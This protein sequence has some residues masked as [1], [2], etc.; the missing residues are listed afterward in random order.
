MD[1]LSAADD[2]DI[3]VAS[4]P[5]RPPGK[6][7]HIDDAAEAGDQVGTGLVDLPEHEDPD[8]PQFGDGK[9]HGGPGKDLGDLALNCRAGPAEAHASDRHRSHFGDDDFS[10]AVHLERNLE[11]GAAEHAHLQAVPHP[12]DIVLGNAPIGR[13]ASV[14]P[15]FEQIGGKPHGALVL[16]F[17]LPDFLFQLLVLSLLQGL[18]ACQVIP[19][20]QGRWISLRNRIDRRSRNSS[21]KR[22]RPRR[23]GRILGHDLQCSQGP[24]PN[25]CAQKHW[26]SPLSTCSG[27]TNQGK[28]SRCS[29][30]GFAHHNTRHS[31]AGISK[32]SLPL[33]L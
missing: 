11:G 10:P 8:F 12:Q 16:G 25:L 5:G 32:C 4:H 26:K 14:L 2:P 24:N 3:A 31:R 30:K 21:S 17:G 13:V 28:A 1:H 29:C 33:K 7:E 15:G 23:G 27:Q 9:I 20:D 22:P 19:K 6:T 18:F